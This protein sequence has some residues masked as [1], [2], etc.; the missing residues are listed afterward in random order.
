MNAKE[1]Y[2]EIKEICEQN[3]NEEIVKKYS[4]YFKGGFNGYGLAKDIIPNKPMM[5]L[6]MCSIN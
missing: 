2:L 1:L 4:R 3:A 6:K 5:K